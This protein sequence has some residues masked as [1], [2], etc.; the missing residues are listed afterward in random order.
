[1]QTTTD[2]YKLLGLP[3][4][5][6]Q[7]DIRKAHRNLV[8]EHHP[9]ANP[10]DPS[11][12]GRF[13]E[14]QRAYEVLSDPEKRREYDKKRR[15]SP[16][17]G[18]RRPRASGGR[19]TE[20]GS[21]ARPHVDLSDLLSKLTDLSSDR[22]SESKGGNS[23]LRGEE[24]ARLAKVLGV[25]VSRISE[26]LGKD[27]SRI[28]KLVGEKMKVNTRVKLGDAR[29]GGFSSTTDG[30]GSGEERPGQSSKNVREKKVKGPKAQRK[31]KR[32]RG[33]R[34]QRGK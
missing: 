30:T 14:I 1:V 4:D 21:A 29:S 25:D 8:R 9:D 5:A 27:M 31:G 17:G 11:S 12:E 26:F 33:P 32:V 19:R 6:T 28:S 3:R 7:D 13:K 10:G 22:F 15:T 16:R 18:S 23:Q 34:A 24:L 20:G 2:F